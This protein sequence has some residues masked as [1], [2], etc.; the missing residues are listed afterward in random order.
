MRGGDAL[1]IRWVSGTFSDAA[2]N[3]VFPPGPVEEEFAGELV[4]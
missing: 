3:H 4:L 1:P 2:N